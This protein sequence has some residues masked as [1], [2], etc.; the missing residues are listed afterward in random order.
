MTL[1]ILLAFALP[2]AP[3]TLP[4][5][6]AQ[7]EKDRTSGTAPAELLARLEAWVKG[8]PPDLQARLAWNRAYLASTQ[9]LNAHRAEWLK[10]NLGKSLSFGGVTGVVRDVKPDRALFDVAG[11]ETEILFASLSPDS[12]L[13]EVLRDGLLAAKSPE[14][15]IL[16]FAAGRPDVAL[17][18]ARKLEPAATRDRALAALVG[19]ELQA[20][21]RSMEAGKI[22][23]LADEL[24]AGWT[25]H[26]DLM[27]AGQGALRQ[28]VEAELLEN[29]FGE[30]DKIAARDRKA[31]RKLIDLV[32]SLTKSKYVLEDLE[33]RQWK[34]VERN[35][36]HPVRLEFLP[37]GASTFSGSAF[38]L[39][40]KADGAEASTFDV[41]DLPG[42]WKEISGFRAKVRV[43]TMEVVD[44]RLGFDVPAK[45]HAVGI[46]TVLQKAVYA[47]FA[48]RLEMSGKESKAVPKRPEYE[49]RFE[50]E[51]DLWK[52]SVD[53]VVMKMARA[54]QDPMQ[55][56][57]V[58]HNGKCELLSLDIRRK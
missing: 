43:G 26:A 16:Q 5:F 33:R 50:L 46:D 11:K 12:G 45:Y 38:V 42:P 47:F 55:I 13:A 25:K 14:E 51:K 54:T 37:P 39:E 1:A 32:P 4:A 29:L 24:A 36:W 44:M 18:L 27:D 21:D 9:V 28:F 3:D 35:Q 53:T 58:Y 7:L 10:R 6:L 15:A 23:A 49:I 22:R 40:D 48:S 2:Q 31:A 19:H 41:N 17:A 34:L 57:F 8:K 56:L 52:M 20:A 30:A